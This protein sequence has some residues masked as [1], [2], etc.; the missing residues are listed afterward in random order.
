MSATHEIKAALEQPYDRM[1]WTGILRR[2][3]GATRLSAIPQPIPLPGDA[4]KA[5]AVELG[6][7]DTQDGWL[8][9]FYEVQMEAGRNVER[10][11]T[12]LREMLRQIY[13]HAVD[14]AIVVFVQGSKWRCSYISEIRQRNP[15]TQEFESKAT[16][17]R[18]FSYLFG[19]GEVCRTAAE[20]F[21][22]LEGKPLRLGDVYEAFSV[23]KLN[24]EFFDAYRGHYEKFW[25]FLAGNAQ[26][27]EWLVDAHAADDA[28]KEK[29]LRDFVKLLLGRIVFLHFL[30]KKGWM[31][32]PA[33][34]DDWQ[35]GEPD[36]LRRLFQ[37]FPV[38]AQFL[39]SALHALFFQTLNTRREGDLMPA[40]L[41]SGRKAPYLNG[42]LFDRTP[43]DRHPIDFPADY[44]HDLFVF[45]SHYNF[46]I[47]ENDP[48]EAEVGIDPEMLG[49]I[50]EN[51]LEENRE[52]GT[53]YTPKEIVHYMCQESLIQYL[54]SHLAE[55]AEDHAPATRE[56]EDL[57]RHGRKA[58]RNLEPR[59]FVVRRA[60]DIERLLDSV[61]V[62]DPAIGSGAFPMGL[63]REI[64]R[65]KMSLDY[66]LDPAEVKKNIIQ[67]SIY[68][69]D[70]ERGAVDIARLRFW[71]ALVVDEEAPQPLPNLDYK[72]MQG[73]SLLEQFE[74]IDLS[75][76]A[77]FGGPLSVP[78]DQQLNV[79][80]GKTNAAASE[81]GFSAQVQA[82]IKK[83]VHEY[84]DVSDRLRK[85]EIHA[86]ID[87]I[88]VDHI[89]FSLKAFERKFLE[90]LTAQAAKVNAKTSRLTAEQKKVFE[91]SS[92]DHKELLRLE[93]EFA[94][95]GEALRK[96]QELEQ[97][98]ER[99]YFLWHLFFKDVFDQGGFD[100][101]IMNPPYLQLSKL[102]DKAL[103]EANFATY[104][105]NGDLYCL[106]YELGLNH[107]KQGGILCAITSN[108][109][110]QTQYGEALRNFWVERANPKLL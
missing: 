13:Q 8:M 32:V 14:G 97:A 83:L 69:V 7:M 82:D 51:L 106:F 39:S 80:T 100:I 91:S 4:G 28:R 56:V 74:G 109:W 49:R 64:L 76:T 26:Y 18:R 63:L 20:R 81:R 57:I 78:G 99:P 48:F 25:R 65:A 94:L 46:T 29:P 42:G 45:F 23:E 35:G 68:G 61:K 84:F 22:A 52:K 9:G 2:V 55:C 67:N 50:F 102:K 86:A 44:F 15:L 36:F 105:K 75:K 70:I 98:P 40:S 73:N 96:L 53:F 3:F 43:G 47:D 107:L 95:K 104:T 19:T 58:D 38:Q 33:D 110:L 54:R 62:C 93:T 31:G 59:S 17:P 1:R 11:R 27:R 6:S 90:Q 79:F 88:V 37:Q 12:G 60:K 34:R 85:E 108:S 41:G 77:L 24:R 66:T 21:A 10:T 30:Q 103:Q 101:V 72:I 92:K 89:E 5:S 87:R 16:E 71:L